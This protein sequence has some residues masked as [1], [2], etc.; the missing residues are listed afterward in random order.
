MV[1]GSGV[2]F[3]LSGRVWFVTCQPHAKV[4]GQGLDLAQRVVVRGVRQ[5][6]E[7]KAPHVFGVL[8]EVWDMREQSRESK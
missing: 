4:V 6:M 8:Q 7:D 3:G 1:P 2:A 5:L